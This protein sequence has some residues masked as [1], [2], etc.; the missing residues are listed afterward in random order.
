MICNWGRISLAVK[1]PVHLQEWCLLK[2]VFSMADN[3]FHTH[4]PDGLENQLENLSC[5]IFSHWL[6]TFQ[7]RE[8]FISFCSRWG[9][10]DDGLQSRCLGSKGNSSWCLRP[11]GGT[12]ASSSGLPPPRAPFGP[13]KPSQASPRWCS[14]WGGPS[15]PSPGCRTADPGFSR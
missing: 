2:L 1:F 4:H 15:C 8:L 11:S 12:R 6:K 10:R 3:C 5:F 9:R 13:R 7:I 14:C